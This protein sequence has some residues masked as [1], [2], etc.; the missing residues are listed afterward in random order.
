MSDMLYASFPAMGTTCRV[1]VV[2]GDEALLDKAT[3]RVEE[4]ESRWSRFRDDSEI[5]R[6][7]QRSG[8]PT[9]LSDDA[10]LLVDH[11]V[12]AWKLTG[13]RYDPTVLHAIE[14]AGYAESFEK[15]Q[16]EQPA[17]RAPQVAAP[18]CA[19]VV[20]DPLLHVVTMPPGVGFDRGG[21]G[22]GLA[23][24]LVVE[25]LLNEGAR[26]ACVDLGGDGR[27]AGAPPE[28]G[29]RIGVGNP[30][31]P[32]SLL[33]VVSLAD[34]GIATSSRLIRRWTVGG[35]PRH[36][37]LDPRTGA[38]VE[39]GLDAVT[40]IARDAW[41]AEVLTKAAFIAGP[42]DAHA[43]I[44]RLGAA[45]LLVESP[46]RVTATGAFASFVVSPDAAPAPSPAAARE[47]QPVP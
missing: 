26:G 30:Y 35:A 28:G 3:R 17:S 9:A 8:R 12:A 16:A 29:W 5:T 6:L 47:P 20:L 37:L 32:D 10:Y 22:K 39:T 2:G 46:E 27:I 18:G 43:L 31:D 38:S 24:D 7:N 4:L 40:V 11:A 41:L 19:G 33:A 21:I 14:A 1:A 45:A 13:S 15:V 42:A 44:E 34:H 36:H 23:A 25:M